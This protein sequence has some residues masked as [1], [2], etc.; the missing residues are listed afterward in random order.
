MK[1]II[2][3]IL[4]FGVIAP[5]ITTGT[6]CVAKFGVHLEQYIG[7]LGSDIVVLIVSFVAVYGLFYASMG[8]ELR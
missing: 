6:L 7:V 4:I 1:D 3:W 2:K 5:I 8:D